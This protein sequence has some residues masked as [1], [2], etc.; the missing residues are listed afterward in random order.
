MTT[1]PSTFNFTKEEI[2]LLGVFK[3]GSPG[4]SPDRLEEVHP[5]HESPSKEMRKSQHFDRD[6]FLAEQHRKHEK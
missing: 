2:A 3:H 4:A 6:E 5:S 1:K